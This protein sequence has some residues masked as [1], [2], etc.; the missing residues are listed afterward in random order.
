[1]EGIEY[2]SRCLN[3]TPNKNVLICI[4]TAV[5]ILQELTAILNMTMLPVPKN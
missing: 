3:S 5:E 2:L 1:M 4:K